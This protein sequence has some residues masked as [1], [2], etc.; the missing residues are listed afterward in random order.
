MSSAPWEGS[1]NGDED[2]ATPFQSGLETW[3]CFHCLLTS[4]AT[5]G[6][7]AEDVRRLWF[8][9]SGNWDLGT[10]NSAGPAS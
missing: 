5:I 8:D 10:G 3:D 6:R 1:W 9:R 4:S 7:V 2:V